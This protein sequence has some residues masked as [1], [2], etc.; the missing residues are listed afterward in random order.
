MNPFARI[1]YDTAVIE[2]A[3]APLYQEQLRKREEALDT[4][5]EVREDVNWNLEG[6]LINTDTQGF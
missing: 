6:A 4:M 1:D 3:T 2:E 5:G